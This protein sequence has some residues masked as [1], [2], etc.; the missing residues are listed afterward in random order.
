M[1]IATRLNRRWWDVLK[2]G[3]AS[4]YFKYFDLEPR[5]PLLLPVLGD[6]YGRELEAGR[7]GLAVEEGEPVVTYYE[8]RFPLAPGSLAPAE[9][10]TVASDRRR[11]HEL[12]ERQ[13]YRL[14]LWRMAG[15]ELPYRRFFDVNSLIGLRQERA[16]VFADSHRL[17]LEWVAAGEVDGLRIDHVDGLR[18]PEDY[19]RRLRRAAPQAWIVVE[20]ILT[21]REQAPEG[22]PVAGTTGYEFLNLLGGLYI[23]PA[24]EPVMSAFYELFTGEMQDFEEVV[25]ESRELVLRTLLW[26]DLERLA[27][28]FGQVCAADPRFRDFTRW[29]MEETLAEL[30]ASLRVYRTYIRL[31]DPVREADVDELEL[32]TE[33]ARRRRQ[34][35]DPELLEFLLAVLL[36]RVN[37]EPGAQA[38]LIGRFQ[39][40]TGPV[41]AKGVEDTALYRYN[42]L[43]CLNEVGGDPARWGSDPGEFHAFC[44]EAAEQRPAAM[45]CT[46]THDTKRSED[47]RARLALLSEMAE[48]WEA[49]VRRWSALNERHRREGQPDRNTEYLYYQTLVGA[50]P[51]SP[52][53]AAAY[54][55]KAAHEAKQHTSWIRPD[56]AYDAA[57]RDFVLA[58]LAD[59][60]F[61]ADLAAFV[62][63]LIEPGRVN[64]L[65][66]KLICLTAPGVPDLYRGSELW[67]LSLVD[68]D[69]RRPVG[70][71]NFPALL[72]RA[73]ATP[74]SLSWREQA[75]SG[76]PKLVL[77]QRVLR[78]RRRLP[79]AFGPGAG[80]RPLAAAGERAGHLVAFLR[81]ERALTLAPRLVLG[82]RGGWGETTISLPSGSWRGVLGEGCWEGEASV[83]ELLADFPVQLLLKD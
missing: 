29:E 50:H 40:T 74:P 64:S 22:W 75:D 7:I 37:I 31:G 54:M 24:G 19:L 4:P 81:G 73:E 8:N 62:D 58:T 70:L 15:R 63:P 83:A 5:E 43:V 14:A 26:S 6:H 33:A 65:S 1:S 82:L 61:S 59:A 38:E 80:Y 13:H 46:S 3:L 57:L 34:D 60:A 42:R 69:N 20:K 72:E 21:G 71:E 28:A 47:V 48:D 45:L 17:I 41:A 55:E 2:H 11:L 68:P 66:Q 25:H 67:D 78:A 44:E 16:D 9:V 39:Q 12:L 32:A 76:L 30:I 35:L 18:D 36:Q 10:S 49:A 27:G 56:P 77:V 53:R 79:E 51:L 23:D 52:E